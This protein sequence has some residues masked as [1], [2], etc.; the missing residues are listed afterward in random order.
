MSDKTDPKEKFS[1]LAEAYA[2]HRPSYPNTAVDFIIDRCH[3]TDSSIL[4]DVGCGTGISTRLFCQ[5]NIPILGIEPNTQMRQKAIEQSKPASGSSTISYRSGTAEQTGLEDSSVDAVL[6]AQAFH[7]FDEKKA[8]SEFHRI[9][10]LG[11]H[12]ILVWN[13]RNESD[14]FT[15]EYGIILRDHSEAAS[16]EVKRGVSGKALLLSD[17]FETV[18]VSEFAN[19]QTLDQGGLLGRAFSTSYAP[20]DNKR[21]MALTE[22][23]KK[24]HQS[25]ATSGNVT[26]K[27][28]T[29]AYIAK[30]VD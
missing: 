17:L 30:T 28:T 7:W 3:L 29:T 4:I 16:A 2:A 27:Y 21:I 5:R 15:R 26:M 6:S 10:K 1:D 18:A 20:R 19:S 13:E 11:G 8:L 25:N 14:A 24:L 9:L 23:L 22:K 12:C